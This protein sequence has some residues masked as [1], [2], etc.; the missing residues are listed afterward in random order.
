M[1][2]RLIVLMGRLLPIFAGAALAF[3]SLNSGVVQDAQTGVY[4]T[5]ALMV[6][7]IVAALL[8]PKEQKENSLD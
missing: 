3:A 6:L 2:N 8:G 5:A 4:I 1:L 7:S